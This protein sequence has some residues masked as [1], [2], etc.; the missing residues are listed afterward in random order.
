MF[1]FIANLKELKDL[2]ISKVLIFSSFIL[3]V[4]AYVRKNMPEMNSDFLE[5]LAF[6]SKKLGYEDWK[7]LFSII[8]IIS[9]GIVLVLFTVYILCLILYMFYW[10]KQKNAP[11][12]NAQRK[13]WV[14]SKAPVYLMLSCAFYLNLVGYYYVLEI[15]IINYSVPLIISTLVLMTGVLGILGKYVLQ[16]YDD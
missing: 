1:D 7:S 15:D 13:Q 8:Q 6:F 3:L 11:Y 2:S 16:N 10:E 14:Q 12:L 4:L 5:T 9:A